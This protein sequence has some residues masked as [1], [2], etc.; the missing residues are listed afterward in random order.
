M[1]DQ[2]SP[3]NTAPATLFIDPQAG[4][5]T[6]HASSGQVV[7]DTT[8]AAKDVY[9]I[10]RGQVRLYMIGA[11][12]TARLMDILGPG[13]WFGIAAFAGAAV[14]QTRAVAAADSV[15]V[16]APV[17]RFRHACVN[18]PHQLMALAGE[19]AASLLSAH[20]EASRLV[21]EDCNSRLINALLRFSRSAASI[22]HEE[23][24]SLRITHDQLAQAIGVARE[25]VSLALTQLRQ[26][27]LLRTGRNQLV[28]NP[29]ALKDFVL[30]HRSSCEC[31]DRAEDAD[32]D[33]GQVRRA[34]TATSVA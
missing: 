2:L 32:R 3:G 21:F 26:Q 17:E 31:D 5:K 34:D 16:Q 15:L 28:F 4:G 1:N 6:I 25:T 27:N 18:N 30:R 14:Y 24:V 19:L 23:G 9:F 8:T 13:Q 29:K 7:Y 20:T 12:Q 22:P 33:N 11:D 10:Q